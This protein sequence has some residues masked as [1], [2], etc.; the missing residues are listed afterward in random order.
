MKI[1]LKGFLVGLILSLFCFNLEAQE[2]SAQKDSSKIS[3]SIQKKVL[4]PK[5]ASIYA[6]LFPG[7]GQV[8][9]GK[10]WKLPII[11]GGYAGLIY[12]FGWNN[13][14][15][16]DYF[17][18]YRTIAKYQ[19]VDLMSKTDKDYLNNLFKIPYWDMNVNPSH[20]EGFKTQLKSGKDYY[21]RNRDMSII[22]IAALHV[23]S[24]IDASVD[25]NLFDFDISDDLS[26]RVDPMP[27]N[28]GRGSQV[29]GINVAF[30]F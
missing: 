12:L 7:L 22:A 30:N 8:Y 20:F 5:K 25:A 1:V 16:S 29:I 2:F 4:S 3:V 24:I 23:L 19:S 21:R 13:N 10:Y 27:M 9:N 18:A 17:D 6:A 28:F 15:Y 11:Y 26:M 14:N